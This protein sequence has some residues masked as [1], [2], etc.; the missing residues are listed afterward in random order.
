MVFAI[1]GE[2]VLRFHQRHEQRRAAVREADEVRAFPHILFRV[3]SAAQ[4]AHALPVL[5]I[6]AAVDEGEAALALFAAADGDIGHAVLAPGK[7]IAEA[8]ELLAL[9]TDD[10]GVVLIFFEMARVRVA[11]GEALRL[12]LYAGVE[13]MRQA[14]LHHAA[15]GEHAV[16]IIGLIGMQRAGQVRPA[17]QILR[18]GMPPGHVAPDRAKGVVLIE[19]VQLAVDHDGAVGVVHPVLFRL[20]MVSCAKFI[21]GS[22]S[23]DE[24]DHLCF[25]F[26]AARNAADRAAASLRL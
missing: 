12:R 21:H 15:A 9:L 4:L 23:C 14:V 1:H 24:D 10:D 17:H 18:H 7:G 25:L 16:L 26:L 11:D 2:Y 8:V 3:V 6:L 5:Q 19:K 20:K 13:D 22:S